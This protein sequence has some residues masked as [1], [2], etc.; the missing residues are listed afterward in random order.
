MKTGMMIATGLFALAC[1]AYAA[2]KN[3]GI[4]KDADGMHINAHGGALMRDGETWYWY[5]EHKTEGSNGNKAWVGVSCYSSKDLLSWKRESTA[6]KVATPEEVA[7]NPRLADVE[8]GCILERPKVVKSQDGSRYV[9]YFHL[10][11]KGKGYGGAMTGIAQAKSPVGPFE[12]VWTGRPNAGEKPVNSCAGE[13]ESIQVPWGS[14]RVKQWRSFVEGGQMSRDM[15]LYTDPASGIVYHIFASEENSCLHVAELKPDGLG[16]TGKWARITPGDWTEAPAVVKHGEWYYLIGSGCTGWR[17][18]AVRYYRAKS[19]WG[20]WERMGNPARGTDPKTRKGPQTTWDGQSTGIFEVGGHAFAMFDR[21]RPSNA[22]DGRY[23]WLPISFYDDGRIVIDWRD[24]FTPELPEPWEDQYVSEINRLAPRSVMNPLDPVRTIS[25]DGEWDFEWVN[26]EFKVESVKCKD[27]GRIVV[28]SCW[29]VVGAREGK[30]WDPPLYVNAI[31]PFAYDPPRV[32]AEPKDKRWT[33]YKFRNPRGIYRREIEIPDDWQDRRTTLRLYGYSSAVY[34]RIDGKTVGY[35]EDGRLPNEWDL[36]PYLAG[37]KRHVLEIEVLKHCDGSYLEDQDFWRLSGLFRSV[38]L[39]SEAKDG[40]RD[41]EIK[42]RVSGKGGVVSVVARQDSAVAKHY[43]WK[44][45]DSRGDELARGTGPEEIVLDDVCLWSH[46][47][48]VLYRV[49]VECAGDAYS[50]RFGFRTVTIE[51]IPASGEMKGGMALC[52]NGARIVVCGVDRHEI[53]AN[54]GY[55]MTREEM[56]RDIELIKKFNIN[57]VRT[58]HYPNDPYWYELCDENGIYVV[59]EANVECHG[60]GHPLKKEALSHD[61]TWRKCFVERAANQVSVLKD[62][63]SI[64]VW[65]LANESGTGANMLAAYK[66]VKAMDPTRPVQYEG[67]FNPYGQL[68]FDVEGSDIICPMYET[69]Q[70]VE[71]AMEKGFR[72]PYILCEFSHAMGNSNGN[73]DEYMALIRKYASFQGGFIWD[74]ADQGIVGKDGALKYGGDFGDV[75]GEGNGHCN[76]LFDA[77]R[78]PHPGAIEVAY[79]YALAQGIVFRPELYAVPSSEGGDKVETSLE[80]LVKTLKLGFWRAPTDNDRGNKMARH[81]A[82]WRKADAEA[83]WDEA[84]GE[85][86]YELPEGVVCEKSVVKKDGGYEVSFALTVPENAAE[87]PRV[88]VKFKASGSTKTV[89]KWH[90]AGPWENYCDRVQSAKVGD[91]QMTVAQLNDSGYIRPQECGHRTK[92]T[93]L[94]VGGI[95]FETLGEPFEFNVLPWSTWEIEKAKH[96]EELPSGGNELHI[97]IDAAMR[98]V[99]GDDSWGAAVH[100]KYR[101]RGA[102]TY[103]L[104]FAVKSGE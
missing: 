25:L 97:L 103:R 61:P 4:W 93:R 46:E 82:A 26:K 65:S 48:P 24:T 50:R 84:K 18:N 68:K 31:Y 102:R 80:D 69:P 45:F 81:S 73:F 71:R 75:P 32:M 37:A 14:G 2:Q 35:G 21:W 77:R 100:D 28:P 43:T 94:D 104:K 11:P 3:G 95:V 34:V 88:G 64:I 85:W 92:T 44:L 1:T 101:L 19:V 9:M 20:P 63:P 22:I 55:A 62:H 27:E 72:R 83:K 98:G 17:A 89:V 5:G 16:Y 90:G 12:L 10:E 87:L 38:E 99:G 40:I 52:V 42:S 29:Q 96:V 74:F 7:A 60:S 58:S 91:W 15:T 76:G 8:A 36:T 78:N 51:D 53:S 39:V 30:N 79:Q 59:A 23:P 6:F 49:K 70:K 41:F 47:N 66:A 57:A 33:S 86:I 56:K 54:G 13:P 67:I